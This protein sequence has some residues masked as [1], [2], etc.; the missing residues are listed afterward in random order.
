MRAQARPGRPGRDE[1]LVFVVEKRGAR[2]MSNASVMIICTPPS[3]VS[4]VTACGRHS[5]KP[6]GCTPKD[7]RTGHAMD[8]QM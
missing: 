5:S 3:L 6:T 7:W 1:H 4:Y 2:Y 8:M